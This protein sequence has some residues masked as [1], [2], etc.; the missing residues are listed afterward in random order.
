MWLERLPVE[1]IREHLTE[2]LEKVYYKEHKEL[3]EGQ[4]YKQAEQ[5]K[6]RI[7]SYKKVSEKKEEKEEE[8]KREQDGR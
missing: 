3:L 6:K 8:R 7:D 1:V 4:R 5:T 2:E